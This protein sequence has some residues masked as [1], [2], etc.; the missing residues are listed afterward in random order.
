[1][2]GIRGL[3]YLPIILCLS[4]AWAGHS[5]FASRA[6]I[7]RKQRWFPY[8]IH[9]VSVLFLLIPLASGSWWATTITLPLVALID[10]M[11]I[12]QARFCSQC[13][14]YHP[15]RGWPGPASRCRLCGHALV[16]EVGL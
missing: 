5:F 15:A 10:Q 2:P 11:W 4:G 16:P 3:M 8:Y 13:G 7:D 1:M 6:P 9:S 14:A 12:H